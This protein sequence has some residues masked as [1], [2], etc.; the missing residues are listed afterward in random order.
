[1]KLE[2]SR[3]VF[4][5]YAFIKFHKNPSCG[6]GQTDRQLFRADGQTDSCSVRT[7]GQTDITK[8]RV[9]FRNFKK[10]PKNAPNRTIR[11]K[12]SPQLAE[13]P[14][15]LSVVRRVFCF[16]IRAALWIQ[17]RAQH[18]RAEHSPQYSTAEHSSQ[19]STAHSTAQ[20]AVQHSTAQLTV[21]HS[22][23]QLTVQHLAPHHSFT[24][25]LSSISTAATARTPAWTAKYFGF[26][27]HNVF[28]FL[29]LPTINS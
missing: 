4:G 17:T 15:S 5:K 26:I 19:Q 12:L 2:F 14:F 6:S 13:T 21:Q 29:T 24:Y 28:T 3:Q 1:M 25:R 18:S 27:S 22:T 20:L 8:L 7:D 16:R 11:T 10:A 23:A 9:A